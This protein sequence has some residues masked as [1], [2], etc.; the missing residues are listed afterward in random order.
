MKTRITK[1]KNIGITKMLYS[2]APIISP[3]KRHLKPLVSPHPGHGIEKTL[4]NKQFT[5]KTNTTSIPNTSSIVSINKINLWFLV[6]KWISFSIY[7]DV[8]Y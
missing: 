7:I 2:N 4:L 3:L 6:T 8:T 1:N 5:S